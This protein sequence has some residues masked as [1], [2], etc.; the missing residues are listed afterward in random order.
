MEKMKIDKYENAM[1]LIE[2]RFG[3]EKGVVLG[4]ATISKTLSADGKPRPSSRM[5]CAYYDEGKFYISSDATKS[6]MLQIEQNNEVSL[7]S[8]D[9][10]TFQGTA[11][12]LG[13]VK[14]EKNTHIIAKFK[15][16]FDWFDEVGD[17]NNPNSI[18]LCVTLTEGI[19]VDHKK[20]YGDAQY[21]VD[22]AAKKAESN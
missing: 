22:F 15:K 1:N 13:W 3:N 14:D 21:V 2:E 16:I 6:K 9:W 19:I 17:E 4:L 11:E 8:M 5:V 18:V 7:C 20:K 12:N 10:C